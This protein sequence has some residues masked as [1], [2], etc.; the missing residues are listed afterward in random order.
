[1]NLSKINGVCDMNQNLI[2]S[3]NDSTKKAPCEIITDKKN[4]CIE[5]EFDDSR[6]PII[7]HEHL[8]LKQKL[9][10][11]I[12]SVTFHN[13]VYKTED[14]GEHLV[15]EGKENCDDSINLDFINFLSV[16][17]WVYW[18]KIKIYRP[19]IDV[20]PFYHNFRYI[21]E[22][23]D[24][25][26][27][28]TIKGNIKKLTIG[29]CDDRPLQQIMFERPYDEP[30]MPFKFTYLETIDL[31]ECTGLEK[32]SWD[33]LYNENLKTVIFPKHEFKT[34]GTNWIQS[35]NISNVNE[36][37]WNIKVINEDYAGYPEY[38][39][40]EEE[41]RRSKCCLII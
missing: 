27:K 12:V 10:Y 38:V 36:G 7:P 40:E 5:L 34:Y 28:L 41:K 37:E 21:K 20:E 32:L 35:L 25:I 31:S 15:I 19:G 11:P 9:K 17:P 16:F 14:D 2:M 13:I 18:E 22:E 8:D 24:H 3:S 6:M 29:S 33:F 30:D 26:K 39:D 1:M 23:R 4:E